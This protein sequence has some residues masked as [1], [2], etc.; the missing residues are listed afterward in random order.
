MAE[1]VV[2]SL[3]CSACGADIRID[4]QFC[5]NCGETIADLTDGRRHDSEPIGPMENGSELNPVNNKPEKLQSAAS[6]KK[7][8]KVFDRS[9]AEYS[10][11][12]RT[13]PSPLF[14]IA[15]IFLTIF[16]GVLLFLAL[17]LR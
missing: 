6:M 11:E 5:Y 7:R 12:K 17:Y 4:S 13:E 3:I 2:E 8:V 10:W 14:V 15:A 9:P 16:A 1:I